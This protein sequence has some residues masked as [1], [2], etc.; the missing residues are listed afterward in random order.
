MEGTTVTLQYH[1]IN[2][3]LTVEPYILALRSVFGTAHSS[4]TQRTNALISIHI[5]DVVGYGEVGLPP[6]K[7]YCYK[8]DYS[9]IKSY[10]LD[11]VQKVKAALKENNFPP[12]DPF[13]TLPMK[14]F[15]DVRLSPQQIKERSDKHKIT[16]IH[17]LFRI[18]DQ[19]DTHASMMEYTQASRCG[20]EMA[21]LDAFG[22]LFQ[23]SIS[24]MIQADVKPNFS[25]YT[26]ALADDIQTMLDSADF[27]VQFTNML[28][29]KLDSNIDRGI[30][31]VNQLDQHLKNSKTAMSKFSVDANASWT[32]DLCLEFLKK[33]EPIRDKFYMMEQPFPST[34]LKEGLPNQKE[35]LEWRAVKTEYGKAG[36]PIIADETCSDVTDVIALEPYVHGVN[37][38]LEKAGGIRAALIA[39]DQALALGLKV[40]IGVMVGSCLNSNA[41]ASLV[42]TVSNFGGD[43]DGGLLVREDSQKFTGGFEWMKDG[44]VKMRGGCGVGVDAK[45]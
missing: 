36:I 9:D 37:L 24:Q 19:S 44:T 45:N 21:F 13:E 40:W 25:F 41:A 20:L 8:A 22:K 18:L 2:F 17:Q 32:P 15:S 38:K 35:D 39:A 42:C 14:Y 33:S 30:D 4:T 3:K 27:G 12:Y 43:L 16:I 31:I 34:F 23:K 6:K 5:D 28:K 26:V 11:Y 7:K 29:I 1:G 10:F